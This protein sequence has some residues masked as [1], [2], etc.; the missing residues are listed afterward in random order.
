MKKTLLLY[1]ATFVVT[2]LICLLF[3][4]ASALV[5]KGLIED[6]AR[7]SAVF[8]RENPLFTKVVGGLENFKIDNYADCI[9]TGIAYHLDS[10]HPITSVISADYNRVAGENVNV[11]FYRQ[12]QG[13][14]V[15]TQ[16][17]SRYWH[18]S[19]GVIRLLLICMDV[20]VMRY[21]IMAIGVLLQLI[22]TGMLVKRK[23]TGLG[24]IYLLAFLLVNGV[25]ALSCFEYAFIFLLIPVATM[26]LLNE[27]IGQKDL[28][29]ELTFLVIGMMTAFFDF[30]TS[31]TL[32]FTIPFTIYYIVM[33]K[34][35]TMKVSGKNKTCHWLLFL[36]SGL[37]WCGGYGGMFLLKW[38]LAAV[39][40]GRDALSTAMDTAMERISGDVSLT[41]Y[42]N[43][44]T[45]NLTEKIKGIFVRNLGCL[46]WGSN[47]MKMSTFLI[48]VMTSV[49][50]LA[51]FWYMARKDKIKMDKAGVLAVVALVPYVRFLLI[52]NHSYIHYFF[53]YR[54]QMVTVLIVFYLIYKTTFLSSPINRRK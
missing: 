12:M 31:E 46:Y 8:F 44:E 21:V 53:T 39:V 48:I 15:E 34:S 28:K 1:P 26:V 16:S 24:V 38:L 50:A 14:E 17:Y 27:K 51:I 36:K 43:G 40:L 7:E 29:V 25:F 10:E 41:L 33:Y 42:A 23:Q 11:S 54:A 20:R 22:L 6:N 45:A 47:D 32:T 2:A 5:P 13:K 3:M 18:G 49:T 19:A 4:M 9:S 30:L 52:S 35:K 37:S